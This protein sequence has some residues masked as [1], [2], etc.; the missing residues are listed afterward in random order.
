MPVV[1]ITGANG[2]V[3]QAL[4]PRMLAEGWQVREAVRHHV[5]TMGD[6]KA[7]SYA[8]S[9]FPLTPSCKGEGITQDIVVVG[10][11]RPNTDWSEALVGVDVVVHL[12]ARVHVMNNTAVDSLTEFRQVNVAGTKRLAQ[13]AA[14]AGVRRLVYISSIKVNGSG[15]P[16]PY[17]EADT[18]APRDPYEISKWEAEQVLHEVAAKT[19]L[20][21]VIFRPP[22]VYGPGVGANFLRLIKF[23]ESG[24]PIPLKSVD[25]RR[26]MIYLGNLIDAII[27]CVRHPRAAGETFCVSDG[28]DIST[29]ELIRIIALSMGKNPRLL[30]FPPAL[31]KALGKLTGKNDEVERLIG[32][33]FI[34]SSKIRNSLNW[35]PPF[36]IEEGMKETVKWYKSL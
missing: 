26:S 20:D 18:P 2:F 5:Q 1:L 8:G 15:S 13:M 27:T 22:L 7:K 9:P 30:P 3:G 24:I 14:A 34:D 17:T 16:L 10:D 23:V 32:S 33:L 28:R 6:G 11:I 31:L 4:C 19:E 36:T 29:P 21:V 12:A 25:N 35:K